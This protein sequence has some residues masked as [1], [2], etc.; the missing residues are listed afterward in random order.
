[1]E[2]L[3]AQVGNWGFPMVVAVWLLMRV[4][5]K[6]DALTVAIQQLKDAV[7]WRL[8]SPFPGPAPGP[9]P[10]IGASLGS[11]PTGGGGGGPGSGPGAVSFSSLPPA[12]LESGRVPAGGIDPGNLEVFSDGR[13]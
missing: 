11:G 4:E 8:A 1:M 13:H 7:D 3:W 6:L 12:S 9:N 10:S 5:K 2:N